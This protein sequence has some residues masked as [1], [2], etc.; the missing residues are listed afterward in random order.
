VTTI[1]IDPVTGDLQVASNQLV[2]LDGPDQVTQQLRS[3]LRMIAGEWFLDPTRGVD[4]R[5]VV[6]VK[7]VSD[8]LVAAEFKRNILTVPGVLQLIAYS[9]TLTGRQLAPAFTVQSVDGTTIKIQDVLPPSTG[10]QQ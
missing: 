8:S 9:Q 1:A 5:G 7:G 3:R 10:G 4:Y 2:L 6:W